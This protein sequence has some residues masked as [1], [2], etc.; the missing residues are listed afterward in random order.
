[1]KSGGNKKR[2]RK[3]RKMETKNLIYIYFFL[4]DLKFYSYWMK[5]ACVD[6]FH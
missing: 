5:S 4:R 6:I 2:K 1:M 3:D